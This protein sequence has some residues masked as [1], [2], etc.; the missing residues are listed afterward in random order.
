MALILTG[1]TV[2]SDYLQGH[3]V[4]KTDLITYSGTDLDQRWILKVLYQIE[5]FIY[6][7]M[8]HHLFTPTI[9]IAVNSWNNFGPFSFY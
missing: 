9:Y 5:W 3:S 7:E 2:E 8:V 4:V 6:V 1:I